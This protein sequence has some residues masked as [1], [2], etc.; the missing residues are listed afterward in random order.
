MKIQAKSWLDDCRGHHDTCNRV[1]FAASETV[2]RFRPTRLLD[3]SR[4]AFVRL[5][6]GEDPTMSKL[7]STMSHCWGLID[8]YRLTKDT[9][10]ELAHGIP[11]S[12]LTKTFQEGIEV[13]RSLGLEAI[14]ID[15]LCILQDKDDL[16]DWKRECGRMTDVYQYSTCNIAATAGLN[17]N[18]GCYSQIQD[19]WLVGSPTVFVS[20]DNF[21][22]P[23]GWSSVVPESFLRTGLAQQ[24]LCTRAWVVQERLLAPRTLH[25]SMSEMFWECSTLLACETFPHGI[26]GSVSGMDSARPKRKQWIASSELDQNDR[27]RIWESVVEDYSRCNLTKWTDKLIALSGIAKAVQ[28]TFHDEYLAGLWR[29]SLP[30]TLL[31]QVASDPSGSRTSSKEDDIYQAPSWSWASLNDITTFTSGLDPLSII[32]EIVSCPTESGLDSAPTGQV[33]RGSLRIRGPVLDIESLRPNYDDSAE[34]PLCRTSDSMPCDHVKACLDSGVKITDYLTQHWT[35]RVLVIVRNLKHR[36]CQGLVLKCQPNSNSDTY[37]RVGLVQF[38]LKPG[39]YFSGGGF[40]LPDFD[41]SKD[42][43]AAYLEYKTRGASIAPS[44]VGFH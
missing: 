43:D 13:A 29:S 44:R 6:S 31:W 34:F 40:S 3:I 28:R 23:R 4:Q 35:M 21:Y 26:P 2:E 8:F 19:R 38:T 42:E 14:W 1:R 32:A 27:D 41:G 30:M 25:F 18:Q 17:G 10:A 36:Q 11:V 39:P 20:G 7:Y 15:S 33:R 22:V 5:A 24:P 9:E 37:G 12:R 16:S